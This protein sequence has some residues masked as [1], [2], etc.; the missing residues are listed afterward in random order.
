MKQ[1]ENNS[2]TYPSWICGQ[3]AI[4]HGGIWKK[5]H[6]ATFHDGFCGWCSQIRSVTQP[7]D[8]GYPAYEGN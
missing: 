6:V 7:K 4:D 2:E 3:C 1:I 8:Y 5:G